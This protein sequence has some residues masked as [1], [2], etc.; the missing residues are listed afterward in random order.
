MAKVQ[1]A[2]LDPTKISGYCGR[3]KCC[4]RY[5]DETYSALKRKLP[6]KNTRV[7]TPS[8]EGKV[9]DGQILTQLVMV[10]L[11]DQKRVAVPLS[12]IQIVGAPPK[13]IEEKPDREQPQN[14]IE[15]NTDFD[16]M[17]DETPQ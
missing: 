17:E 16:E 15:E 12:E 1:K 7:I 8:G 14:E 13:P 11:D 5:E 3:L 10:E 9:I 4:L 6:R 2:T